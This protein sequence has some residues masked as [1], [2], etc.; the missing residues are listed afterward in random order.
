V[1]IERTTLIGQ[2]RSVQPPDDDLFDALRD[3]LGPRPLDEHP[4]EF[5]PDAISELNPHRFEM[6]LLSGVLTFQPQAGLIIGVKH[7]TSD[8]FWVRG[9]Y[10]DNPVFPAVLMLEVAGQLCSFYWQ[11]KHPVDKRTFALGEVK[12]ARWYAEAATGD[13]LIVIAK[14]IDLNRRKAE[15]DTAGFVHSKRLFDAT[16][17]G[18][19]LG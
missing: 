10:P 16:L 13:R 5:G 19:A 12:R 14:A 2:A 3:F 4:M 15:F 18:M 7:V 6:Q 17:V 1:G 9:Y 8:E 11:K